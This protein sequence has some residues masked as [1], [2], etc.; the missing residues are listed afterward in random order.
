MSKWQMSTQI[1]RVNEAWINAIE[2]DGW[3]VE[4]SFKWFAKLSGYDKHSW[5]M[6]S[7]ICFLMRWNVLSILSVW[8]CLI[9][10]IRR[11][12]EG[13]TFVHW[14]TRKCI[15]GF[16]LK[17]PWVKWSAQLGM[18][19]LAGAKGK[20]ILVFLEKPRRR[21]AQL[22]TEVQSQAFPRNERIISDSQQM[23]NWRNAMET[24][25]GWKTIQA[26]SFWM[27]LCSTN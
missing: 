9:K 15:I 14:S 21:M 6:D 2:I 18:I 24:G 17:I 11:E 16:R 4:L 7:K 8:W 19:L 22:A 23:D 13:S 10:V 20:I 25:D 27:F 12:K 5:A 3:S 26:F 1:I